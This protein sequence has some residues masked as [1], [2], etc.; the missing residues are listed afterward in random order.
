[1]LGLSLSAQASDYYWVPA[2]PTSGRAITGN[3]TWTELAHWASVSGGA[4]SAYANVPKNTDNVFFD[5]KSFNGTNQRVT[6]VGTVTC[7]NMTRSAACR[8]LPSRR[9]PARC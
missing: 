8:E 1:M 2:V 9:V 6:I 3:G 7:Q 4:G 5:T